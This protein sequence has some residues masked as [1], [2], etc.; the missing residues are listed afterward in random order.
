MKQHIESLLHQ[1]M[2]TLKMDG[3]LTIDVLPVIRVSSNNDLKHGDFSSN[4]ALIL[5]KTVGMNPRT[6][7]EKIAN[8][9]PTSKQIT[10]VKIADPGFINFFLEESSY[11]S[12]IHSILKAGQCYGES[13][14]GKGKRV[15]IE[16]VS[17]NPTGPLHVGH[18]RGAA[19]GACVANLLKAV[20]YDVHREYY[21][22]DAG[23]Q[24]D[25]L[26][27]SVWIRYLQSCEEAVDIPKN[28]YQ[29]EYVIDIAQD[30]KKKYGNQFY[31][32]QKFINEI[33]SP[34]INPCINPETYLDALIKTQKE[35][36]GTANFNLIFHAALDN[37]LDDI[38][39]D[40]EEFGVFYETWFSEIQL[41]NKELIQAGV[42]QLA[43]GGYVY[44]KNGA[45]WFR[46]TVFGDEKDRV[47]MRKNGVPTYF[48]SDVAYHLYKYDQG[49]DLLVDIFGADH[50]GY[51]PRICAFLK[52]LGK[53][54]EKLHI[55]LVQFAIL[56]RGNEKISMSTRRGMFIT[57]R[58]L[59]NEV[60]NDAVRF[61]YIMRKPNQHLNF[62]IELAKSKSNENPVY[63]IQYAHARICSVFRQLKCAQKSR[64]ESSGMEN[65][66]LLST[67][68]EKELLSTLTRYPEL[69][70]KAAVQHA[71]HLLAHYLQILANQFHTYY[72]AERFLLRD[73]KLRDA[74]LNLIAAVQQVLVNGLTLLGVSAPK[75][76]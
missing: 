43:K 63:Y 61:F 74:R 10:Q 70:R 62:D 32:T 49:Y 13:E 53:S 58:E 56:Y 2:E 57:L 11:Y 22:N 7:A 15:H 3:T 37:I 26:T 40:L 12:V 41:I 31:C 39:N 46:A 18:G 8:A 36:L 42:D 45:Q 71:P 1:A 59:R 33:F 60:G 35:I 47:L 23:R 69:L 76:M 6:L 16:Y 54:T 21:V 27:L 9:L 66:S 51:I 38:K 72:N 65:L 68:Y 14:F 50:H 48:A 73:A 20:G 29:G 4:L 5:S 34:E 25:V 75:E 67:K 19:Y 24:M 52:G 17:A 55:L 28:A 30:L 44:E 64:D